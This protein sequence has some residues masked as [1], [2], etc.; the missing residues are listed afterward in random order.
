MVRNDLGIKE[1][2]PG[3]IE[4]A[5]FIDN[6]TMVHMVFA[7]CKWSGIKKLEIHIAKKIP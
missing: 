1:Q 5:D 4:L 6:E 3:S 2:E 7:K